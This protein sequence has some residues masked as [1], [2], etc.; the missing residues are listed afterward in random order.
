MQSR[1]IH[2][3][4]GVR[5]TYGNELYSKRYVMNS[6][7]EK[8][9]SYGYT[10]IETPTFEF[11]DIFSKEIGTIPSNELFKF[12]DKEGNTLVLRP[13]FTPS[14]ARCASKYYMHESLPVRFSYAGNTFVNR[15]NLQGKLKENT[16]L[17]VECIGDGSAYADV[18]MISMLI[19]TLKNTG[20][21]NFQI[22]IGQVDFFKGLCEEAG[23]DEETEE[24][25]RTFINNKNYFG[26]EELLKVRNIDK[27]LIHL[28]AN[29]SDW[30]GSMEAIEKSKSL[31]KNKR[32]LNAIKNLEKIDRVLKDF[33]KAKYISYD[34]GILSKYNYYT[35][36]I[37]QAYTYG[38]GDTIAKGG[39]YDSL[40]QHFGKKAEAIGFVIMIGNLMTALKQNKISVST[41]CSSMILL[42]DLD[43][44]KETLLLAE[45]LRKI[46]KSVQVT[47]RHFLDDTLSN[48]DKL[49]DLADSRQI[50]DIYMVS[51]EHVTVIDFESSKKQIKTFSEILG[52][53]YER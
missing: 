3:P 42:Y 31:I 23:L 4:E 16:E 37:F 27:D 12:F 21:D 13:D 47:S 24:Q 46:G 22:S 25:V 19:D 28:L 40:L 33:D 38:V 49:L 6:I 7:Q 48:N 35:G 8:F 39:R 44:Y 15:S 30:F 11:F 51:K 43:S 20:L 14:M 18:E 52:D 5:D 32:S 36:I 10:E 45:E 34:L 1:N 50:S 41:N 26:V 17:G 53:T 29:I 9:L 2:T